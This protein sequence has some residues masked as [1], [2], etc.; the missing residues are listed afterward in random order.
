M[1][2]DLDMELGAL[3]TRLDLSLSRL[4]ARGHRH[5]KIL[6]TSENIFAVDFS[7]NYSI[8]YDD[9]VINAE[10]ASRQPSTL[11]YVKTTP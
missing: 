1:A 5:R 10:D 11:L 6:T 3:L 9:D 4:E 8:S 2:I 7:P